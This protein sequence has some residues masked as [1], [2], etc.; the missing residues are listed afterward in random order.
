[1]RLIVWIEV[2]TCC[3]THI[4]TATC[5]MNMQSNGFAWLQVHELAIYLNT[6][7]DWAQEHLSYFFFFTIYSLNR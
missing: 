1:M 6:A 4:C 2:T 7:I 3:F 5:F